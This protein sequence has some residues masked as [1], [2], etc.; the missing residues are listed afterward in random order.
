MSIQRKIK[1]RVQRRQYRVRAKFSGDIERPRL[2][3][4]RSLNHIGGQIIDDTAGN[5]LVSASSLGQAAASGNKTEIAH[6]IGLELAARALAK[7]ISKISFDRGSC[8][9]HGRVKAFAE[10]LRAGGLEF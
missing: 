6:A 9:Y 3:V 5:T 2:S 10:G 7:G 4:F 8:L 1:N